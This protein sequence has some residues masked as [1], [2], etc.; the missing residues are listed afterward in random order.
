MIDETLGPGESGDRPA[1]DVLLVVECG[2]P[3]AAELT[4]AVIRHCA[5]CRLERFPTLAA[6]LREADPLWLP[7]MAIVFEPFPGATGESVLL[8][9][10][11]RW[12]LTRW[13]C[14]AGPWCESAMRR[15]TAWP[16]ATWCP[17]ARLDARLAA[18]RRALEGA[19]PPPPLTAERD[20]IVLFEQPAGFALLP[21]AIDAVAV[22]GAATGSPHGCATF[23]VAAADRHLRTLVARL[24]REAGGVVAAEVASV[25]AFARPGD[26]QGTLRPPGVLVWDAD[27]WSEV[28]RKTLERL[29]RQ[30]AVAVWLL[31]G[32]PDPDSVIPRMGPNVDVIAKLAL[33]WEIP[34]RVA[35]LCGGVPDAAS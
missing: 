31:S 7:E 8:A 27:P 21:E 22:N 6:A 20:E 28:R 16:P 34:R 35:A 19:A 4:A 32:E 26:P 17:P 15:G 2:S 9:A 25:E 11:D 3:C 5:P 12:P 1:R 29:S 10:F 30:R 14:V 24:I 33:A 23:V 13:I 18:E